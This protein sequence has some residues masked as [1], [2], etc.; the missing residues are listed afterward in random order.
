MIK[1][2]TTTILLLAIACSIAYAQNSSPFSINFMASFQTG[3]TSGFVQIPQGGR[4]GTTSYHQP[5]FKDLGIK[6]NNNYDLLLKLN[7]HKLTFYGG[8]QN[9]RPSGTNTL[10]KTIIT[11]NVTIPAGSSINS[12]LTLDWTRL[13]AQYNFFPNNKWSIAPQLEAAAMDFDY[14]IPNYAVSRHFLPPAIRVG[15][16]SN[17]NIN[18]KFAI[19]GDAAAA[20]PVS[21]LNIT[22]VNLRL[23]YNLLTKSNF[24]TQIFA[25]AGY[26]YIRFKDHQPTPN[27]ILYKQPLFQAGLVLSYT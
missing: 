16:Y 15:I 20:I 18:N 4:A 14:K 5:T 3:P 25:G 17:Y 1:K 21:N 6:H 26:L 13:G 8:C 11:H 22:T 9:I 7:W 12:K 19:D 24:T 23:K 27:Y 2:L 10:D